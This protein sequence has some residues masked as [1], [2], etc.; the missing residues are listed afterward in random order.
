MPCTVILIPHLNSIKHEIITYYK[1]SYIPPVGGFLHPY[2][3]NLVQWCE[4]YTVT[5]NIERKPDVAGPGPLFSLI[6]GLHC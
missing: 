4:E 6:T 1:A 5:Y 3:I 2:Y